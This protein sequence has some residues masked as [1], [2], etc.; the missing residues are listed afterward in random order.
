[1]TCNVFIHK[2]TYSNHS[3]SSYLSINWSITTSVCMH[4][5][6]IAM[7]HLNSP[8]LGLKRSFFQLPRVLAATRFYLGP[9]TGLS[10]K[11]T[12][13]P[14]PCPLLAAAVSSDWQVGIKRPDPLLQ[15]SVIWRIRPGCAGL[16]EAIC[17]CLKPDSSPFPFLPVFHLHECLFWGTAQ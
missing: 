9:S 5:L 6:N 7:C 1:M 2:H 10:R 17:Y 3:I 4:I 13:C 15:F 16:V 12:T 14:R 8:S 11:K